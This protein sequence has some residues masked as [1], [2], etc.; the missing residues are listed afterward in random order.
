MDLCYPGLMELCSRCRKPIPDGDRGRM[1][2]WLVNAA[3]TGMAFAHA[4]MWVKEELG[5]PYCASCR[6][7][8]LPFVGLLVLGAAGAVAFGVRLLIKGP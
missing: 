8:L 5:K 4:G 2:A 3:A 6:R 7:T 1:P